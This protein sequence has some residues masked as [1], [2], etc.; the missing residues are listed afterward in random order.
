MLRYYRK[1]GIALLLTVCFL[2][3]MV[4]PGLAQGAEDT[5]S[6]LR[7][8]L[9]GIVG[10]YANNKTKL[11]SWREVVALKEA[12]QDLSEW[13]LPDWKIEQLN[14]ESQ[15]TD[16]AGTILG[17][18]A[19][20]QDPKKVAVNDQVYRDL[21]AELASLQNDDGSFGDL[22]NQT[23]WAVIALDE[24]GGE[25]DSAKAIEFILSRQKSDGGFALF[26]DAA[27]PDVT[28]DALVALAP[29]KSDPEVSD[30]IDRAIECLKRLQ[31]PDGG[32]AS[33]GSENPESIAAVIRGLLACGEDILSED[34]VK[35]KGTMIDALFSFQLADG[36]FV[37]SS[38][39]TECNAMATV[40]A[41]QA[42]AEMVNAGIDYIVKTG[43]RHTSEQTEATVRVRVEGANRSLADETVTVTGSA[44]DALKAAVGE[45]NLIVSGDQVFS[46]YEEEGTRVQQNLYSGWMYYVIRD[47]AIDLDCFRMS[48]SAYQVKDGDEI[49]F[50][51]A[52]Y[53]TVSPYAVKTYLPHVT[54]SPTAPTAGQ[55]VTISI[56]ALKLNDT[57]DSLV[58]LT[59]DEAES[60]GEYTVFVGGKEYTT[61]FGQVTIP[62]VPEGTL[63][64][65]ITNYNDEG[66]AD[67]VTFKGAILVGERAFSSVRVRVEG[68]GDSLKDATVKVAGTALD[69]LKA[70]VGE[71]NVDAPGGFITGILGESGKQISEGI[72]TSWMH[73]VIRDGAI[74]PGA[75]SQGAGSYNVR[76]GD[77]VVFYIGAMD[78]TTW[79]AKT[80]IPQVEI[81]PALPQAGENFTI[82]IKALNFDWTSGLV[83]LTPLEMQEIGE[84]TVT[85]G[86][87]EYRT[88][89]GQVVI[90]AVKAGTL[91]FTVS[92]WNEAGYPDVVTY[93]GSIEIGASGGSG[94]AS[95]KISVQ[96][97]IVGRNGELIFGP[98][99]VNI[100]KDSPHGYTPL[101]ALD[102]SGVDYTVSAEYSGFVEAISGQANEGMSGWM[103]TVNDTVPSVGADQY[104]LKD[105]DRIIW[106]YSKD[107][108]EPPPKWDDLVKRAA[109]GTV[110]PSAA[111]EEIADLLTD[112]EKSKLT[113]GEVITGIGDLL[114][115]L[116][117]AEAT[118]ELKS[119]LAEAVN[120]LSLRLAKI[121]D[122]ALSVRTD[123]ATAKVEV[124][125]D[126][127]KNQVSAVKSAVTL[128]EKLEQIGVNEVGN[129]ELEQIV[130]KLPTE[131]ASQ[132]GFTVELPAEAG[133]ELVSANLGLAVEGP[134][135]SLS[136]PPEVLKKA[137]DTAPNL[138]GLELAVARREPSKLNPFKGAS[139]VGNVAFDLE[140][141]TITAEGKKESLK[142]SF[143]KKV[144]V[145]L[146][147]EGIDLGG[148][149]RGRLAVYR[150]KGDGSW[151]FVGGSLSA[152]EKS[153][154][155][156]TD[157]LSVYSLMEFQNPFKDVTSHW[158]RETIELMAM[159]LIAR[160][161]SED[162]FAPDQKLSRAQFAAFLV[163]ALDVEE[164]TPQVRTFSDVPPDHWGYR[165]IEAAFREGLVAGTGAG[166]F[167]PE[168]AI[169][170]EEMAVILA[171]VLK[172]N[173]IATALTDTQRD[174]VLKGY[175]DSDR[176][177]EWAKEGLAVCVS[178]G[179]IKGRAEAA[180]APLGS[181]TRAEAVVVLEN[182][183]RLLGK[184]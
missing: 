159:R 38:T 130:V 83:E 147:L 51:I 165:A 135:V 61:Q 67:V 60:I 161:I 117:A 37:H 65:T 154:F 40:Q 3:A 5:G 110:S 94:S 63:D 48:T 69:A 75:F 44:L 95:Q 56:S 160:G 143:S 170:R 137:C 7:D 6:S 155:F 134:E 41:L 55:T 158:A 146:S 90:P 30:A 9:D 58:P 111:V 163:R 177:S 74:E 151:E 115:Q 25:Y 29:H 33:W 77:E 31:L 129:L 112:L 102:A 79:A 1:K 91:F 106:Y 139:V 140:A 157:H 156:E 43:Q 138:A 13:T 39:E 118:E 59:A 183:L 19:A 162:S 150:Q 70:A 149:D 20:G 109:S 145:T 136:L 93:K 80:F 172:R 76:D 88:Q 8:A 141:N 12:G 103:F 66:Y 92:N 46:I 62:D 123:G 71:N 120:A 18:L 184:L 2:L 100:S 35:E 125:G 81:T 34:W 108:N 166:R 116:G 85:V 171:A 127:I 173:G 107:I 17:M 57:W 105:G 72:S 176:I 96:L 68:A 169:K 73:Y 152:D 132:K 182:L 23:I 14:E 181:A 133:E 24:A 174:E 148:I 153:Y 10:Y 52:A 45:E 42:V 142:G 179:I 28:G 11:D 128:A 54:V 104:D 164:E 114:D 97:A 64:F 47:G 131:L 98:S 84:F 49:V 4:A 178:K 36:S 167:E 89:D 113:P 16:Y 168:R 26:G 22:L 27:D 101:G 15:P 99:A 21:V 82:K 53:Q 144:T 86:E 50:Y 124:D 180:L 32:F 121:P 119:K 126:A 78:S 175:G 87:K 122:E